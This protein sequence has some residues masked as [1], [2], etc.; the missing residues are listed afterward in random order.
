MKRCN[1]CGK[2]LEINNFHKDKYSKDGHRNICKECVKEN[3]KNKRLTKTCIFCGKEYKTNF[4]P[5]KYCSQECKA[6]H[7]KT[8]LCGDGNP[9]WNSQE[10]KCEYCGKLL[11]RCSSRMKSTQHHFCSQE[12][13]AEWQH[14]NLCGENNPFYDSSI[15]K[16]DR[17]NGRLID[18]YNY[19]RYEVYK[20]DKF[21]CQCCGDNKGGNLVAHHLN[22]YN[23]DKEHRID[24]NNGVTLCK[25][26]HKDFHDL[27]GYGDN[28]K[29]QYI[30]FVNKVLP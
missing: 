19:W 10:V 24:V 25:S 8:I 30:E 11:Q 1:K 3:N 13:K 27:Y 9:A 17:E 7:Q 2:E 22:G 16:E 23:W 6:E 28:T 29:E 26:C 12:C 5:Q 15:S 20:R 14:E 4:S 21:T 18:G